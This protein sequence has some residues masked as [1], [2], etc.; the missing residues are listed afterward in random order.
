MNYLLLVGW[1]LDD[2]TEDFS[3]EEMINSFTLERVNRSPAS[4]DPV[5]LQTFQERH[6]QRLDADASWRRSGHLPKPWDGWIHMA[7]IT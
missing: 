5:K 7:V 6:M 1:S 4:F 2:S 3:R